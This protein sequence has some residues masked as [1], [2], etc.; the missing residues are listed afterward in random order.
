ML[1]RRD[2]GEQLSDAQLIEVCDNL[3][4]S[5]SASGD[6]Q[7]I[8]QQEAE[9]L[10]DISKELYEVVATKGELIHIFSHA[11]KEFEKEILDCIMLAHRDLVEQDNQQA[12]RV[13]NK[14]KKL[15]PLRKAEVEAHIN[16]RNKHPQ[17]TVERFKV[18][19]HQVPWEQ[20]FS[21]YKPNDYTNPVVLKFS[22][23][24][25]EAG[26]AKG[27]ADPPLTP[28]KANPNPPPFPNPLKPTELQLRETYMTSS[29]TPVSLLDAGV[30]FSDGKDGYEAGAPINPRGR[31]GMKGRGLLGKWGPNHAADPIVTRRNPETGHIEVVAVQRIDTGEYA[32]PGGMV[33]AGEKHK[34][35]LQREF[36]EEAINSGLQAHS[37]EAVKKMIEDLFASGGELVYKGY[38][39]DPRN[40][41]NAWMETM[42][43][44][45][46]C[47]AYTAKNLVLSGGDDAKAA[48]WLRMD[49]THELRYAKL[50]ADHRLFT[51]KVINL[52]LG[53]EKAGTLPEYQTL[54]GYS[55]VP[56][57]SISWRSPLPSPGYKPVE[58]SVMPRYANLTEG[59][60]FD[61]P[62]PTPAQR[63][64]IEERRS[65]EAPVQFDE[66]N[67]PVNPRGRT[68]VRGRGKLWRY[69][70]NQASDSIVTRH[71]PRNDKLQV[72]MTKRS[73]PGTKKPHGAQDQQSGFWAIPGDMGG[74]FTDKEDPTR[75]QPK[76]VKRAF[77]AEAM[78]HARGKDKSQYELAARIRELVNELFTN[79]DRV[80]VYKGY[81][82]DPRNT[83]NAWMETTAF[84][85]HCS[86]ELG[87]L[88][89]LDRA[90]RDKFL[91]VEKSETAKAS[92][93]ATAKT[94]LKERSKTRSI[95][96]SLE[97]V[98]SQ[99][100]LDD[101]CWL[102]IHEPNQKHPE[103]YLT[104]DSGESITLKDLGFGHADLLTRTVEQYRR[105]GHMALMQT[106]VTWGKSDHVKD[107]LRRDDLTKQI[108]PPLLQ[109]SFHT[110]LLRAGHTGAA[111]FDAQ[112]DDFEGEFEVEII[113]LLLS[114]GARA[115]DV[116]LG[117]LFSEAGEKGNLDAFGYM[118]KFVKT[119]GEL[120]RNS[121][122]EGLMKR[123]KTVVGL[124][125]SSNKT[126]A[127]DAAKEATSNNVCPWKEEHVRLME[128]F[129]YGFE[130]YAQKR[131]ACAC[132]D[133]VFWA[134]LCG[135]FKLSLKL[136]EECETP[137]R[138]ALIA[139]HMCHKIIREK[140]A[141]IV[142][143][144]G[145]AK[146]FDE[147]ALGVLD[148]L[149]DAEVA[150]KV[151]QSRHGDVALLCSYHGVLFDE[152]RASTLDVAL[153]LKNKKF[154]A[155][156]KTQE[157]IDDI[158]RG[159]SEE[160]YGRVMLHSDAGRGH[161][162]TTRLVLA[163]PLALFGIHVLKLEVNDLNEAVKKAQADARWKQY[164]LPFHR[165]WLDYWKIPHVKRANYLIADHAYLLGQVIVF[166][167]PLCGDTNISHD[168]L[169]VWVASKVLC[170][171]QQAVY[172]KD[173]YFRTASNILDLS[174]AVV[175]MTAVILR[176][177]IANGEG[178]SFIT[179]A[180][181]FLDYFS[182][183]EGGNE[184]LQPNGWYYTAHERPVSL[185]NPEDECPWTVELECLRLFAA[186]SICTAS[187]HLLELFRFDHA[188]GVLIITM[189]EMVK[190]LITFL[191]PTLVIMLSFAFVFHLLTP[192]YRTADTLENMAP[193]FQPI[194]GL[195]LDFS[196]SG[197]FF[198][199]FW[200]LM[201]YYE[202]TD[203]AT[204]PGGS[205]FAPLALW[206]Y[207][208][209]ALVMLVNLLIAMFNER[210][211][212]ISKQSEENWRFYIAS[213]LMQNLR[214]QHPAP[215]PLNLVMIPWWVYRGMTVSCTAIKA[216]CTAEAQKRRDEE[217]REE[218]QIREQAAK[219]FSAA[220]MFSSKSKITPHDSA[221]LSNGL[222][223]RIPGKHPLTT[224][225]RSSRVGFEASPE[226]RNSTSAASPV[227]VLER[228]AREFNRQLS[229]GL[230]WSDTIFA[231][232]TY[233]L[234]KVIEVEGRA[235][236][237]Y[238]Q[239][240]NEK[241]E[242][243]TDKRLHKIEEKLDKLQR[244]LYAKDNKQK[245]AAHWQGTSIK[246]QLL[247]LREEVGLPRGGSHA[248]G[249]AAS[250]RGA[251]MAPAPKLNAKPPV[252]SLQQPPG[253][254]A[255]LALNSAPLALKSA[256]KFS[257][258]LLAVNPANPMS[259]PA[260]MRAAPTLP[261]AKPTPPMPSC[262]VTNK[263]F[264]VTNGSLG[265]TVAPPK[266]LVP[267]TPAPPVVAP[268]AAASAPPVVANATAAAALPA[269][270]AAAGSKRTV[271]GAWAKP[272]RAGG[273][274][275]EP[276]WR[277]NPQYAIVPT[278]SGSFSVA[279]SSASAGDA[280]Q[281]Y[282]FVVIGPVEQGQPLPDDAIKSLKLGQSNFSRQ[283]HSVEGLALAAGQCYVVVPCTA[284][285]GIEG[286]FTLD[287]TC[288]D[289]V[290]F[291]LELNE[292]KVE[293]EARAY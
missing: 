246:R 293:V 170:E 106:V 134:I 176:Y 99:A 197:P 28:A 92:S 35:T 277:D 133:L 286:S 283:P 132:N 274:P 291:T 140:K 59:V 107:L 285:P 216:V 53:H 278:A 208:L 281:P 201:G 211:D 129:I 17:Y 66:S 250:P 292:R 253:K 272:S 97:R 220:K 252:G 43:F 103:L 11:V 91:D 231:D 152:H 282:G 279:L 95:F 112:L 85:F 171:L 198:L 244:E 54:P 161:L 77:E 118:K 145:L 200:A 218:E 56:P 57:T 131:K 174:A 40:T 67:R 141:H 257:S 144:K 165:K 156:T 86:R 180:L 215:T 3:V 232:T 194:P 172:N 241:K 268:A 191:K 260:P 284:K 270:A 69:G 217:R 127:Y 102:T 189:G 288:A 153:R 15:Q 82:D 219:V 44:H 30:R 142:G 60:D 229:K 116:F 61:A 212:D 88:L 114:H 202:P 50:Y 84:H 224:T 73:L 111:R 7:C 195:S 146:K 115:A 164:E 221:R 157:C 162:R 139:R 223:R 76:K 259:N 155:H 255:P 42:A 46:H 110:A 64:K 27:W 276:T 51:D 182:K 94:F 213:T 185:I 238:L 234:P 120:R 173:V 33:D 245:A 49:P 227:A 206:L 128:Q 79:K 243:G 18:E 6:A 63:K 93:W 38:V 166:F 68:G 179:P 31:T 186:I 248:V 262:G 287:V 25:F 20:E 147:L 78:E 14:D 74:V 192:N 90:A 117:G 263:S 34:K 12:E 21:G 177:R 1:C 203:L 266:S 178:T 8:S 109:K 199:T 123:A 26:A 183:F 207:L 275:K 247:E 249:I 10:Q 136:W 47:D 196:S 150:R 226:K 193:P 204:T 163:M 122:S 23:E 264:V 190:D 96:G 119:P 24:N 258:T 242:K 269:T 184:W 239:E 9:W 135:S 228:S 143:L 273:W 2:S 130:G 230:L 55:V 101:F 104:H 70:A 209:V 175:S 65:Y 29:A 237:E 113:K 149:P 124:D 71:H 121:T 5:S 137:L 289:R 181:S 265:G 89:L 148:R 108:T 154:V 19:A 48:T 210:Y 256:S 81:M 41:D 58:Y 267:Q 151:L 169:T 158:W 235:R 125:D 225:R 205:F 105:Q 240:I 126:D 159:R 36:C 251:P 233:Q 22:R 45:F 271:Q 32:L 52:L 188:T 4:G 187:S 62:D 214:L 80:V 98:P 13:H 254:L 100:N 83:D 167:Q 280:K 290:A 222:Q 75:A 160:T 236:K 138:T 168:L 16:A 37:R 261:L 72:V 87:G 39:D